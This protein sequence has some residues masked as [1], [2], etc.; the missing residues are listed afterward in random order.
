MYFSADEGDEGAEEMREFFSPSQIDQL[1][2]LHSP[3]CSC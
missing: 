3:R 2:R 1:Q